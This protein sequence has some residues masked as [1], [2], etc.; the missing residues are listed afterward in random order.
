[1][2]VK[3]GSI[4]RIGPN[5]LVTNSP[6]LVIRMSAVRSLYRRS[7]FYAAAKVQPGKDNTFSQMDEEK[8][9]RR[10]AQMADGVRRCHVFGTICFLLLVFRQNQSAY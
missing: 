10:R 3:I 6:D 2:I 7:D 1:M 9:T 8:H 4:A 5:T